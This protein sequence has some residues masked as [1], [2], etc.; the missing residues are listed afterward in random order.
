MA[1]H[2]LKIFEKLDPELLE[3]VAKT[4]EFALA[5]GALSQ[6]FNRRCEVMGGYCRDFLDRKLNRGCKVNGCY[7]KFDSKIM[8]PSEKYTCDD[9]L[10]HQPPAT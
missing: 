4:R 8:P 1:E 2:P 5:D 7:S 6:N 9:D 3:L 10:D